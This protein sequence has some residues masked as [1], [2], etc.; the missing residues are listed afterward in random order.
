MDVDLFKNEK[1]TKKI[2]NFIAHCN[3]FICGK[4]LFPSSKI[5]E[6][7]SDIESSENLYQLF[8]ECLEGFN[9]SLFKTKC[10]IKLPTK[11]G[12]FNAP[13]EKEDFLALAYVMMEDIFHDRQDYDVFVNKFFTN[14]KNEDVF[15][16]QVIQ[17]TKN[18]IAQIFELPEDNE[19]EYYIESVVEKQ[20][21]HL[22][23]LKVENADAIAV[24]KN[25]ISVI[26]RNNFPSDDE[27]NAVVILFE[28]IQSLQANNQ[29]QILCFQI[30]LSYIYKNIKELDF[31]FGEL[32]YCLDK[33]I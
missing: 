1:E 11:K 31:M 13:T 9:A 17:P 2:M 22:N 3:D 15:A 26:S 32:F 14:E 5:K 10:L 25:L 23:E 18:L 8:K 33:L 16:K 4:Y 30:A 7:F 28:L 27:K 20:E 12:T 24:A 29:N 6:I 21:K 19:T